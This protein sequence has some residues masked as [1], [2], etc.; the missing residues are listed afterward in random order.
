[1][2]V[3]EHVPPDLAATITAQLAIPVI[4][5]GAGPACDGQVRVTADLLG[6][7]PRQPPFSPP[8]LQGRQLGVEALRRW[9]AQQ[10]PAASATTAGAGPAPHC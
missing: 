8:L 9:I 5:I 2:L 4:G 3:L 7:T 10:Q 6:L 1:A